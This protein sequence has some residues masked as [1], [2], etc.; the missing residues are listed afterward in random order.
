MHEEKS[1]FSLE[2]VSETSKNHK[3]NKLSRYFPK[4]FPCLWKANVQTQ[5]AEEQPLLCKAPCFN[6]LLLLPNVIMYCHTSSVLWYNSFPAFM[7]TE[8]VHY[9]CKGSP[10]LLEKDRER[11][12]LSGAKNQGFPLLSCPKHCQHS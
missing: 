2:S 3:F 8:A 6:R 4:H 9:N 11:A 12:G 7:E 5:M 10:V 1:I